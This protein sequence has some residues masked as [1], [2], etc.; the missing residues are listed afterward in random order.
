ADNSILFVS[1]HRD[2]A[3]NQLIEANARD[4]EAR[5][6]LV[7]CEM[8]EKRLPLVEV[9]PQVLR[10]EKVRREKQAL[11]QREQAGHDRAGKECEND[12]ATVQKNEESYDLCAMGDEDDSKDTGSSAH[13]KN[14]RAASA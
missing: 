9:C 1:P 8:D 10:D 5:L 11:L 7:D 2:I 14:I 3:L 6:E 12:A 13:E 4:I